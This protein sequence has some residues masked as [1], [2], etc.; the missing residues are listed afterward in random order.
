[1]C[2]YCIHLDCKQP[3]WHIKAVVN[4]DM[5]CQAFKSWLKRN[6]SM[7]YVT[8]SFVTMN[9]SVTRRNWANVTFAQYHKETKAL[10]WNKQARFGGEPIGV[11]ELTEYPYKENTFI[12]NDINYIWEG[13]R[14]LDAR[15][16]VI[17][18]LSRP[19]LCIL[20]SWRRRAEIMTVV[21]FKILEVFPGMAP[22]YSTDDE[23]KRCVKALVRAIG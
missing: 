16:S 14:Y 9:K 12:M 13:F 7:A 17:V 18:P 3:Q 1:M 22:K 8:P 23:I 15:H 19:L 20:D 2:D 5:Y 21:P 11:M 6:I 4:G 10:V